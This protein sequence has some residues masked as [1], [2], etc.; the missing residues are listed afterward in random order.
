[1]HGWIADTEILL[2]LR[3]RDGGIL[4]AWQFGIV[5]DECQVANFTEI[6]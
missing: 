3:K 2:L 6:K 5:C 4:F 1:L